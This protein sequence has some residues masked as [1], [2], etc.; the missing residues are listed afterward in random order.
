[1][2]GH[3]SGDFYLFQKYRL[4]CDGS[5]L[6]RRDQAGTEVWVPLGSR[7]L[8]L[9]IVLIERSGQIVSKD[10]IL[11]GVWPGIAVA[12]SN[13]TVQISAL[14]RAL[15]KDLVLGS[16]IQTIPRHGYRFVAAVR[17]VGAAN[18]EKCSAVRNVGIDDTPSEQVPRYLFSYSRT[19]G[20]GSCPLGWCRSCG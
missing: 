4:N 6:F 10:E 5:G 13:L 7:A 11:E 14:R 15:D 9:L 17:R 8:Q 3:L 12:E 18:A 19:D 16:C 1:M 20:S 2:A